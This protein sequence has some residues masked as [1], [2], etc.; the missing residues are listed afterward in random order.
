MYKEQWW[1]PLDDQWL[2]TILCNACL[3]LWSTGDGCDMAFES[4]KWRSSERFEGNTSILGPRDPIRPGGVIGDS[5]GPLKTREARRRMM[6]TTLAKSNR[7]MMASRVSG[8]YGSSVKDYRVSRLSGRLD[9]HRKCRVVPEKDSLASKP[10]RGQVSWFEPQNHGQTQCGQASRM[11]YTW[12]H[13]RVCFEGKGTYED[14]VSI[15]CTNV[16]LKRFTPTPV[17]ILRNI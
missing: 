10:P 2:T 12:R 8:P 15:W 9:M 5:H 16:N 7:K 13:P 4:V 6:K 11:E 17:V 1:S 3:G 14:G